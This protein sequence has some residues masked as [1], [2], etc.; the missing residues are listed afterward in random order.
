MQPSRHSA[1]LTRLRV[2]ARRLIPSSPTAF[3]DSL[4]RWLLFGVVIGLVA[5][6]GAVVFYWCLSHATGWLLVDLGGYQ[7][8]TTRGEGTGFAGGEF[9]RPWAI[10]VV[11]TA[12]ALVAGILVALFAPE[13]R[14]HGT[15]AAIAAVHNNPTGMRMRAAVVK[16][17]ASSLI[18]GSGGSGGREGPT[19]Q[20]CATVVSRMC[21][22]L[23]I[24]RADAR[25]AVAAAMA[26]GIGAIFRAP[27]GGAL[28]GA[29]LLYRDDLEADA[30]MPGLISSIVAF[31]VY[32]SV[33]GFQPIFGTMDSLNFTRPSEL[34]WFALLGLAAGIAGRCYARTFYR[35]GALL[36]SLPVP[37]ALLPAVG[38]LLVGLLGLVVPAVLGTGYGWVQLEMTSEWLMAAPLWL[39]L[40]IPAAK[41]VATTL[42]IGSGGSGGIFGPGMVVGGATGALVWRLLQGLP[43]VGDSPAPYVI[44][45]MIACFGAVAH[46]PLGLLLMVGEM[47]GNLSLLAPA[48]IAVALATVVVGNTSIFTSQL[49]DRRHDPFLHPEL[50]MPSS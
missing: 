21:A 10:P 37:A 19:A 18:I 48:M 28:L 5:G 8:P 38:G 41:I 12:G 40:V 15:D 36:R 25:I 23:R 30:I 6:L 42:S 14:G 35:G 2:N 49:P 3:R 13:A 39:V 1:W 29:E 43:G 11:T 16:V 7:P 45:A 32:G 22:V 4:R 27:L 50:P 17:I 46:A 9:T 20:I 26:A 24:P 33:Y 47:T 44:I 31:A 34:G